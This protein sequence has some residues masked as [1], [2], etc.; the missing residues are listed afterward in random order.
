MSNERSNNP[1]SAEFA[2]I[3]MKWLK[4]NK[5]TLTVKDRCGD[6][7]LIYVR[8]PS[9]GLDYIYNISTY[10]LRTSLNATGHFAYNA[11]YSPTAEICVFDGFLNRDFTIP[12]EE[13]VKETAMGFYDS[14]SARAKFDEV[15]EKVFPSIFLAKYQDKVTIN[16][17]T[18]D[19]SDYYTDAARKAYLRGENEVS[20]LEMFY[21]HIKTE[22]IYLQ[23]IE[24]MLARDSTESYRI[25]IDFIAKGQTEE[26]MREFIEKAITSCEKETPHVFTK[27]Y[28]QFMNYLKS[29]AAIYDLSR[30]YIPS[31]NEKLTRSM[32]QAYHAFFKDKEPPRKVKITIRG[33]NKNRNW[34]SERDNIDIE[35]KIMTMKV[36]P[37]QLASPYVAFEPSTYGVSDFT[38][39]DLQVRKNYSGRIEIP[40]D[41]IH[42]EDILKIEYGRKTIW[43]KPAKEAI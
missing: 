29:A 28:G 20:L 18:S 6:D 35:G 11:V 40:M 5:P 22:K 9:E 21:E 7:K 31:E 12:K 33:T 3:C 14:E 19:A 25:L 37:C 26:A 10:W 13:L 32:C 36:D 42:T 2:Q 4:S 1:N 38:C 43:E 16:E 34:R 15:F 30:S 24:S 41:D 39:K 23:P 27:M 8:I 17:N